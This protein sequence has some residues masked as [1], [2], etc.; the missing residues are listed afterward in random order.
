MQAIALSLRRRQSG[1][2][3]FT[4]AELMVSMTVFGL[5]TT[6]AVTFFLQ[7]LNMY[8][9]DGGKL[10]VNRDIRTLTSEM[11]SNA[12]YANYFLI[13]PSF[14]DRT[15]TVS[16]VTSDAAVNHGQSGDFLVLVYKDETDDTKVSRL[17]GYYRAPANASDP[18]SQG[19]VRTFDLTISPS[20]AAS[21]LSLLPATTTLN[22]NPEVIELSKGLSTG[23]LFYNFNDRS[24]MIKGQI[25]H[26]GS[27]TKAATN[28][29]NFTV[30]P[31]G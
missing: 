17:V 14:T 13:Y 31:R 5:A 11:T 18:T 2:R 8:H 26:R 24:V 9:Y 21:V 10:L 6:G 15:V 7:A 19:P 12:T 27:L 23:K 28:T 22:T 1:R 3:A 20:T 16:G 29:Y 4:L 30:S 25:I